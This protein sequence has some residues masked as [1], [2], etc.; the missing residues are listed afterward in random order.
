MYRHTCMTRCSFNQ[1][2][3]SWNCEL[4]FI[5]I[6]SLVSEAWES[7]CENPKSETLHH[8]VSRHGALKKPQLIVTLMMSLYDSNTKMRM[9]ALLCFFQTLPIF[10]T[11]QKTCLLWQ[12][13][14]HY[15]QLAIYRPNGLSCGRAP[16]KQERGSPASPNPAMA[17]LQ[18]DPHWAWPCWG[19]AKKTHNNSHGWCA[20]G[21]L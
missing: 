17:S 9:Q 20:V 21:C 19:S 4:G 14:L 12:R 1:F 18:Q 13:L 5:S 11:L 8:L 6:F 16:W 10:V 15:L 7:H 3:C 2:S